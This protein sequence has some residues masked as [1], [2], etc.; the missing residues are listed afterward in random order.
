MQ[1]S[2]VTDPWVNAPKGDPSHSFQT[3]VPTR[4]CFWCLFCIVPTAVS[5]CAER[6]WQ[7][8]ATVSLWCAVSPL[9]EPSVGHHT[10]PYRLATQ[11]STPGAQGIRGSLKKIWA[12]QG[13]LFCGA[14]VPCVGGLSAFLGHIFSHQALISKV[15][16]YP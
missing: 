14:L 11:K 1:R 16:N 3:G 6:L 10:T 7:L 2:H 12:D 8:G 5:R 15:N 9:S 13:C 4:L